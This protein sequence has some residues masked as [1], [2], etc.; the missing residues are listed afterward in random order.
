[1][2]SEG[3][4][5]ST[6][7]SSIPNSWLVGVVVQFDDH[8]LAHA[9]FVQAAQ[10]HIHNVS[11]NPLMLSFGIVAF[12][13]IVAKIVSF[14]TQNGVDMV[15]VVLETYVIVLDQKIGG[16]D[17][18]V[19]R[20]IV[21]QATDP[22]EVHFVQTGLNQFIVQPMRDGVFKIVHIFLNEDFKNL[23]LGGIELRG[24]NPGIVIDPLTPPS[25]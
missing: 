16:V 18:V 11:R 13:Q 12:E 19:V 5:L 14:L 22:G 9:G 24:R 7:P 15:A 3:L 21:V 25:K 23:Q 20:L 10:G 6:R 17:D 2:V 4:R 8:L 1:M